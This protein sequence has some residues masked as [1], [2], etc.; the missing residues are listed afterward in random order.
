MG[1]ASL[2]ST[3]RGGR[4]GESGLV[5]LRSEVTAPQTLSFLNPTAQIISIGP[6][7]VGLTE[8]DNGSDSGHLVRVR[9]ASSKTSFLM[10]T[11]KKSLIHVIYLCSNSIMCHF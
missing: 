11:K 7:S 9:S 6:H 4:E 1:I 3:P 2:E 5:A 8:G 10:Y